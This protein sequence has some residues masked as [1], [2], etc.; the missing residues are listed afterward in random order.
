MLTGFCMFEVLPSPKSQVHAVGLPELVSVNLTVNGVTPP[1]VKLAAS[2]AGAGVGEGV[3][4]PVGTGLGVAVGM[5]VGVTVGAGDGIGVAVG[6]GPA[7]LGLGAVPMVAM[8]C[9]FSA[10]AMSA[11]FTG[12]ISAGNMASVR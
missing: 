4:A 11:I 10:L 6:A 1:E 5:G 12:G 2:G 9:I 8:P 7:S 3:G